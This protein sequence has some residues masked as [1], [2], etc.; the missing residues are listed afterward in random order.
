MTARAN[1][2]WPTARVNVD[3]QI[4]R[5]DLALFRHIDGQTTKVDRRA[6]LSLQH[7]VRLQYGSYTYLEIGSFM[8]GSIQ[9]HLVDPRCALIYSI[10]PRPHDPV[11]DERS[12]ELVQYFASTQAML[13]GLARIPD[14]DVGKIVAIE[15]DASQMAATDAP[16]VSHL[17]FIDGEHTNEAVVS[18]FRACLPRSAPEGVIAFHD[19]YLVAS[20]IL[21][22]AQLIVDAKRPFTP[23]HYPHGNVFAFV[24]G[25][26]VSLLQRFE[27]AGWKRGLEVVRVKALKERVKSLLPSSLVRFLERSTWTNPSSR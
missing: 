3:E 10:D 25:S 6:L 1:A 21:R 9:P 19:C 2:I 14:G 11:P 5:M 24:L 4:E 17:C 12:R 13:S 18:D 22:C 7:I 15:K 8:G 20:G 26:D 16:G 27:A 23:Y